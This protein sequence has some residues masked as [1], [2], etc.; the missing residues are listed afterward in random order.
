MVGFIKS[1]DTFCNII[2]LMPITA[3]KFASLNA[4]HNKILLFFMT[5]F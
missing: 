5:P 3:E 2:P 4:I 1:A